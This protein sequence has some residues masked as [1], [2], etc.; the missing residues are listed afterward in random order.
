[1]YVC[2]PVYI[3]A[4]PHFCSQCNYVHSML[5]NL[6]MTYKTESKEM[7]ALFLA[8]F[9]LLRVSCYVGVTCHMCQQFFFKSSTTVSFAFP[10]LPS[11]LL[12]HL[13][14]ERNALYGCHGENTLVIASFLLCGSI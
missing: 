9:L 13:Q 8:S 12:R 5:R 7:P 10:S 6:H 14:G 1:M 4:Q 2:V 11:G 3:Y